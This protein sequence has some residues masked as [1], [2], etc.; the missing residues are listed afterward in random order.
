MMSGIAKIAR[1]YSVTLNVLSHS[2]GLVVRSGPTIHIAK[3]M[4]A[5]NKKAERYPEIKAISLPLNAVKTIIM[6]K[7]PSMLGRIITEFLTMFS[8]G[9]IQI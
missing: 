5:R 4:I 1:V 9:S 3:L 6:D 7:I 8:K 2:P